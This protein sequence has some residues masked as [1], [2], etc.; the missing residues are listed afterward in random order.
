[1][2]IIIILIIV[3]IAYLPTFLN[4]QKLKPLIDN[5]IKAGLSR[6]AIVIMLVR[7]AT[8][9]LGRVLNNNEVEKIKRIVN[10]RVTKINSS[11]PIEKTSDVEDVF[12]YINQTTSPFLLQNNER[13]VATIPA[14]G[15]REPRSIRTSTGAYGGPSFKVSKN[16]RLNTGVFRSSSQSHEELKNIDGGDLV[17]TNQKILFTGK[18]RTSNIPFKKIV[19]IEPYS[20]YFVLHKD[21]KER[22]QYFLWPEN[23][24]K[25]KNDNGMD[26]LTG[27]ILYGI[28][29]KQ[30]TELK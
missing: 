5:G 2:I 9:S 6:E 30:L 3:G 10:N 27:H 16:V 24:I 28:I 21:G 26:P 23:L 20:N 8:R 12:R 19:S 11:T 18:K 25:V 7:D 1:M 22:A 14:V 29:A 4:Q 17:I 15:L 13:I